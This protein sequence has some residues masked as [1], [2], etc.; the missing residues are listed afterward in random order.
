M[1]LAQV[2]RSSLLVIPL[3]L[4]C[5]GSIAWA[6]KGIPT[7]GAATKSGRS[8]SGPWG[9]PDRP[10]FAYTNLQGDRIKLLSNRPEDP[11]LLSTLVLKNGT[12]RRLDF[13]K[14]QFAAEHWNGRD[15]AYEF[16][17]SPGSVYR[18]SGSKLRKNKC[19]PVLTAAWM[20][21]RI[22]VPVLSRPARALSPA[23]RRL[24][25]RQLGFKVRRS[26]NLGGLGDDG[27]LHWCWFHPKGRK[28]LIALVLNS[29]DGLS[30]LPMPA[31]TEVGWRVGGEEM[32]GGDL[33]DILFA[34]R[35][36]RGI[37]LA[38]A[39]A[40]EEGTSLAYVVQQGANLIRKSDWDAYGYHSPF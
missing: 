13:V 5:A 25:E 6:Q 21:E 26:W 24:L 4:G 23:S 33:V 39:W 35:G 11:K 29:K 28:G 19:Y 17:S 8:Y 18:V 7:A 15:T 12:T 36:P 2:L 22:P 14:D 34:C 30:V 40:G 32:E 9:D 37:E 38:F 16:E 1:S 3:V 10:Y 31:D 27:S 20:A